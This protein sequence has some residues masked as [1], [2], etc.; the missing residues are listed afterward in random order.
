MT[1]STDF[2]V[3]ERMVDMITNHLSKADNIIV[4]KVVYVVS[5]LSMVVDGRW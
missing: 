5:K 4:S 1:Y 2:I 3:V